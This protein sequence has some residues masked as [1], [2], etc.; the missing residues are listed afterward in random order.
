[1]SV[2]DAS[3]RSVRLLVRGS[4]IAAGQNQLSRFVTRTTMCPA[5]ET[6]FLTDV[7]GQRPFENPAS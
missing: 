5:R 6:A 3:G 1:M 4:R 7:A 2:V